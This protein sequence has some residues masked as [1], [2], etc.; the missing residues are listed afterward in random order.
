MAMKRCILCGGPFGL[1]RHYHF[2]KQFCTDRC[3]GAYIERRMRIVTLE[4]ARAAAATLG[5]YELLLRSTGFSRRRRTPNPPPAARSR[6]TTRT[7]RA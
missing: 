7:A 2:D 4:R 5:F 1:I 3:K 6:S